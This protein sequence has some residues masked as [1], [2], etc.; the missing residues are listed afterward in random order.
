MRWSLRV[1]RFVPI[2]IRLVAMISYDEGGGNNNNNNKKDAGRG[3]RI[4]SRASHNKHRD[5]ASV[6]VLPNKNYR[7]HQLR[8]FFMHVLLFFYIYRAGI[9]QNSILFNKIIII[10]WHNLSILNNF[11]FSDILF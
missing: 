6:L 7:W 11:Y 1:T 2:P 4:G 9:E 8:T 3:G 5:D 10:E